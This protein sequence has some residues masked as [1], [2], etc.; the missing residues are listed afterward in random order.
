MPQALTVTC[1]QIGIEWAGSY[2][3]KHSDPS[4]RL[5]NPGTRFFTPAAG[6]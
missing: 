5:S 3:A 6:N 1:E 2:Q 4:T